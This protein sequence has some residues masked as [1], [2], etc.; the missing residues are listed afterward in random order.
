MMN[1]AQTLLRPATEST[2]VGC[3]EL[4][5]GWL[6]RDLSDAMAGTGTKPPWVIEDLLLA[7]SA[8]QVSAH[9][10]S[11]KSLAWLAACLESVAIHKV[12]GHFDASRVNSALFIE[13]EDSLW[14][15]EE[16]I[17]GVARGL[18]LTGAEDVPGFHYLRSGPFDLVG[19]EQSLTQILELYRPDFVVLSTLQ[20]LIFGRDWNTQ[21]DM[22]FVNELI[23]RLSAKHCPIVVITHS[24]W[25]SKHK[26]AIGSVS[27]AANFLTA[28]HFEKKVTGEDTFVHVTLDSK[29]GA[30]L[31]DFSLKLITEG[32]GK[33]R[34]VRGFKFAGSGWPKGLG[35]DA[36]MRAISEDPDASPKEIAERTGVSDRYVQRLLQESRGKKGH[37]KRRSK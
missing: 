30:E 16:R 6:V 33:Q 14:V 20:N 2:I 23:V 19:M 10:H 4:P 1:P 13:T 29:L 17:R 12:W 35:K 15:L 32:E 37:T 9:P 21:L 8:T 18:G 28:L 36:V 31:A 26:R 25:N 24:P 22:Q 27:Q 11:M 7:Q 5:P 3:R 34:E